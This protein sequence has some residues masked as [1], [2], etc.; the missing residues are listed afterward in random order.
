MV[1]ISFVNFFLGKEN[2]FKISFAR[3]LA[4]SLARLLLYFIYFLSPAPKN[5][6]IFCSIRKI[7]LSTRVDKCRMECVLQLQLQIKF[8]LIRSCCYSSIGQ[9]EWGC[10]V[11]VYFVF[12][13]FLSYFCCFFFSSLVWFRP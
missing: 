4:R 7:L 5:Q 6:F 1:T 3:S 12:I 13:S 11:A 10:G 2:L 9:N 8:V